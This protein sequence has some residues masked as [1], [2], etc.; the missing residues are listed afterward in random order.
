MNTRQHGSH[1]SHDSHD[2]QHIQTLVR[3]YQSNMIR[4]QEMHRETIARIEQ[5]NQRILSAIQSSYVSSSVSSASTTSTTST[6]I[7]PVNDSATSIPQPYQSNR[8]NINGTHINYINGRRSS[9]RSASSDSNGTTAPISQPVRP[10]TTA[11]YYN[12][13]LSTLS[14]IAEDTGNTQFRELEALLPTLATQFGN[15]RTSRTS[16][17]ATSTRNNDPLAYLMDMILT[18][19][20]DGSGNRVDASN[21]SVTSAN[22]ATSANSTT[23]ARNYQEV[24]DSMVSQFFSS[25]SNEFRQGGFPDSLGSVPIRVPPEVIAQTCRVY[26]YVRDEQNGQ[27]G[28]NTDISGGEASTSMRP[29]CP[30]DLNEFEEGEEI[31]QIRQCGHE[32]RASNLR[33]W[34]ESNPRCPLCRLD[35]RESVQ[36]VDVSGSQP[37]QTV[38][39]DASANASANALLPEETKEEAE[40]AKQ[41]EQQEEES[42]TQPTQDTQNTQN[43]QDVVDREL[44]TFLNGTY[45]TIMQ[46]INSD[47][48]QQTQEDAQNSLLG[49]ANNFLS[50]M[51]SI[52][53]EYNVNNEGTA[54]DEQT[55]AQL[56]QYNSLRNLMRN[57]QSEEATSSTQPTQSTTQTDSSGTDL[58]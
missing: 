29:S 2:S 4:V 40:E 26:P 13:P 38:H 19:L 16:R 56:N 17:N 55:R 5:M 6:T 9:R 54:L 12:I 41:Q 8:T 18:P 39:T 37:V 49:F 36:A 21:A 45:T 28:Q 32:F 47:N 27:N 34:F 52:V 24:L 51:D 50:E 3:L 48:T 31:M 42:N 35:V 7:P 58:P 23:R 10:V 11:L 53:E 43:V 14:S 1:D 33:T 44:A 30:I 20:R 22:S 46:S 57:M 15:A 25:L